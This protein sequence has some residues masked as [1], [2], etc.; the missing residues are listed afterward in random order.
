MSLSAPNESLTKEI[1]IPQVVL[2]VLVNEIFCVRMDY[3]S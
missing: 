2:N 3:F 1:L